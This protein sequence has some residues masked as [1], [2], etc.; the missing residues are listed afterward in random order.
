MPKKS[1]PVC[2]NGAACMRPNCHFGHPERHSAPPA[3]AF[4][5]APPAPAFHSPPPEGQCSPTF[6][7]HSEAIRMQQA[8]LDRYAQVHAIRLEELRRQKEAADAKANRLFMSKFVP[9]P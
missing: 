6:V 7:D 5:F 3:P 9:C 4:H 8:E 2:R 1:K